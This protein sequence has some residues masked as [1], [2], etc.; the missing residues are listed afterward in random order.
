[1]NKN[2]ELI[3]DT[4]DTCQILLARET[5]LLSDPETQKAIVEAEDALTKVYTLI[6]NRGEEP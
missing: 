3:L 2:L 4:I 6:I 1:M 5:Q